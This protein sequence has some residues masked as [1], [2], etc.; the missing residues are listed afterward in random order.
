MIIIVF[1]L[2][3]A[4][5][6]FCVYGYYNYLFHAVKTDKET[7]EGYRTTASIFWGINLTS[8]GL[9]YYLFACSYF[10][11]SLWLEK[12]LNQEESNNTK[13]YVYVVFAILLVLNIVVPSSISWLDLLPI[14]VPMW[15]H[16][17][18]VGVILIL[19]IISCIILGYALFKINQIML[20]I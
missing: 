15:V 6:T 9:A 13:W 18:V 14:L 19:Q 17:A 4:S 8:Y 5:I 7:H 10:D 12:V 11:V 20:K 3:I 2:L 1:L 16:D